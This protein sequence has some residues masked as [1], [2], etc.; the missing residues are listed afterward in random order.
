MKGN[1]KIMTIVRALLIVL[2]ISAI[3][4]F[5]L[6]L[7]SN[8]FHIGMVYPILFFM[9][10]LI[11]AINPNLLHV[12]FAPRFKIISTIAFSL[13]GIILVAIIST[14]AAMGVK[15]ADRPQNNDDVTVVVLGCQVKGNVPSIM[16][17]DRISAAYDYLSKNEKAVCIASGGQGDGEYIS[18][19][20]AIK[21]GLVSRGIDPSRIII[22]DKSTNTAENIKY[23][24][25]IIRKNGLSTEIAVASDNFHQ[26]RASIFAKNEGLTAHSI[27]NKTFWPLSGSYWTREVLAVFSALVRGR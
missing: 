23:S 19:A 21:N 6:P 17:G 5:L 16:L 15:A 1:S 20:E 10:V 7:I 3:I 18:E 22:E 27:G 4:Y 25:E 24:A 9:V 13:A 2:S 8:V 12:I 14:L 26:L 11:F